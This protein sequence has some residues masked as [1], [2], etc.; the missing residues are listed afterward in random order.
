M[1]IPTFPILKTGAVTQY[2]ATQNI[3][4][5][6]FV[7]R[8]LDGSNQRYRKYAAP[9]RRWVIRLAMLDETEIYAMEK[10]FQEQG[11]SFGSFGFIDPWTQ[12]LFPDCSIDQDELNYQL[13]GEARGAVNII[14]TE[15]G[16]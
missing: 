8:F 1:P 14:V 5:S 3:Q 13:S 6:S 4:Y 2:P 12:A 16:V 10:F 7:V 15:N 11:G 9:L